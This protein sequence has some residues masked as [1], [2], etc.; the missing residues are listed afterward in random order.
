MSCNHNRLC[1]C[2]CC[3]GPPEELVEVLLPSLLEVIFIWRKKNNERKNVDERSQHS[4]FVL[5][6][7]KKRKNQQYDFLLSG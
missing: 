7:T 4:F 5:F 2:S 6:L 3:Q 1:R